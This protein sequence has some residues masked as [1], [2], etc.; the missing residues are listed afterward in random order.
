VQENEI[1]RMIRGDSDLADIAQLK[2]V[3]DG[4]D[5]PFVG[6]HLNMVC[7]IPRAQWDGWNGNMRARSSSVLARLYIARS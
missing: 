7:L 2:M 4:G 1:S 3:S 6:L 5:G